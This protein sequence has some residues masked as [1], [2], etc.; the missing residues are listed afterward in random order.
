[1][2]SVQVKLRKHQ[3]EF[4]EHCDEWVIGKSLPKAAWLSIVTGGGK[5][6]V[7]VIAAAKLIRAG[8][9][10]KIVWIV[11]RHA[12]QEQAEEVFGKSVWR[13]H[14][15]HD[16]SIRSATNDIDPSRGLVGYTTTY[17]ALLVDGK[18]ANLDELKR[19]RYIA[20]WDEPHHL[21]DAG[22]SHQAA[23]SIYDS[24]IMNIFMTGTM[25]RHDGKRIA[26]LPYGGTA[27]GKWTPAPR[28]DPEI[29]FIEYGRYDAVQ[30][31]A[32]RR[33]E[34]SL[35]NG[36][37]QWIDGRSKQ[38]IFSELRT[39]GKHT[40]AA[41]FTALSTEFAHSLLEDAVSN[42]R[43]Y[44][45]WQPE[46]KL[47]I[48]SPSIPWA[49][50]HLKWLKAL[51]IDRSAIAVS[52]DSEEAKA[53]IRLF[54]KPNGTA[55]SL[56]ALVTVAMA[57]EG[58]DVPEI[59]HIACLT[60]IRSVPWIEQMIG[61]G[62]RVVPEWGE[63]DGQRCY[64]FAPDDEMFAAIVQKIRNEE[65]PEVRDRES[66]DG[67]NGRDGEEPERSV[68]LES[69][70]T[71]VRAEALEGGFWLSPAETE[72]V[73]R[74]AQR[75]GIFGSPLAIA[76]LLDQAGENWRAEVEEEH[77]PRAE[78][79]FV[80]PSIREKQLRNAIQSQCARLDA[81]MVLPHR[82]LELVCETAVREVPL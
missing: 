38:T 68:P 72:A 11:P 48:V 62:V 16:F 32:I 67:T 76:A 4:L 77:R 12:L 80:P 50:R 15:P 53:N 10:D 19:S 18:R 51:G 7:P 63:P 14:L 60:Y 47:L 34:F 37:A 65:P 66:G 78:K 82:H 17:Q 46:S 1:M 61:R 52:E 23:Q 42:W 73:R 69:A 3:Q 81:T 5:S 25:E 36:S 9:A 39:A 44:R 71:E 70:Y 28:S 57:Y 75:K 74:F 45:E 43:E 58:L 27:P 41:L 33:V 6:L 79:T 56:E 21:E 55:E 24:A 22:R 2:S 54:K 49:R 40:R 20:I 31:G 30:D 59:T 26:F 29:P 8:L 13:S 64:V 35:S